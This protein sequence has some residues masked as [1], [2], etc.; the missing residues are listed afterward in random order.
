M[1]AMGGREYKWSKKG[2]IKKKE[3]A[4]K[5][6]LCIKKLGNVVCVCVYACLCMCEEWAGERGRVVTASVIPFISPAIITPS[7]Q[8]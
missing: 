4:R 6:E 8:R 3:K 7:T 2:V 5:E 1:N